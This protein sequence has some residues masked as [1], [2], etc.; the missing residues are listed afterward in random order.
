MR[1]GSD[2]DTPQFEP[3]ETIRGKPVTFLMHMPDMG[4]IYFGP[5]ED[6]EV[7]YHIVYG[8]DE[9]CN[10][11]GEMGMLKSSDFKRGSSMSRL[12]AYHHIKEK[13]DVMRDA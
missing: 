5:G 3:R 7:I 12:I 2:M 8:D 13:I 11:W 6:G 9:D 4:D 1:W 10:V